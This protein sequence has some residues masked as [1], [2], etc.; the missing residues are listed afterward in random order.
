MSKDELPTIIKFLPERID[1]KNFQQNRTYT[2]PIAI[3]NCVEVPLILKIKSSDS[4][5]IRLSDAAIKINPKQ[6][7]EIVLTIKEGKG[8][9]II[10]ER[11]RLFLWVKGDLVEEKFIIEFQY[12]NNQN[13]NKKKALYS[14]VSF[15]KEYTSFNC[16]GLSRIES[17]S[18][19]KNNIKMKEEKG[20]QSDMNH[21]PDSLSIINQEA[22]ELGR[23]IDY[24]RIN[25]LIEEN[26]KLKGI[27]NRMIHQFRDMKTLLEI[28]STKA[29]E[30]KR[31]Y[32]DLSIQLI[33]TLYLNGNMDNINQY[34]IDN[35]LL[36]IKEIEIENKVLILEN[37]TLKLRMRVIG[38]KTNCTESNSQLVHKQEQLIEKEQIDNQLEYYSNKNS[39][40]NQSLFFKE[41]LNKQIQEEYL[42]DLEIDYSKNQTIEEYERSLL[43]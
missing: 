20:C 26:E 16:N 25:M 6:S 36:K 8:I 4:N 2:E 11:K 34:R 41:D 21:W 28:W 32:S 42:C 29:K 12:N 37:N 10:N 18:F 24:G 40:R 23:S 38:P 19:I 30:V 9:K 5:K 31:H 3:F 17:F 7:K 35:M 27:L 13:N 33:D 1:I 14:H 43:Q 39:F 22:F 15:E